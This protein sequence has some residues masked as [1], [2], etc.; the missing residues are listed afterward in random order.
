MPILWVWP[1]LVCTQ[2]LIGYYY[3]EEHAL[4]PMCYN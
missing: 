3:F 1:K 2:Y 4:T